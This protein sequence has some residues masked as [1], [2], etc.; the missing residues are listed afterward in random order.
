MK[1]N[2]K[3]LGAMADGTRL[4]ILEC[5]LSGERCVCEIMPYTKRKQSNVSIQLAKLKKAGILKSRRNGK[6]VFYKISDPRI[7]DVFKA[8]GQSEGRILKKS[9][10]MG[11][12]K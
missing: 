8:L 5:L 3:I 2:L 11:G 4:K 9:C 12:R 10:C 7:C 1:D 6:K